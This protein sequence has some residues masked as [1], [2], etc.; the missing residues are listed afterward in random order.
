MNKYTLF[1]C[2][3]CNHSSTELAENQPNDGNILL[4]KIT[5]LSAE[6]FALEELKIQPVE[7]LWNCRGCVVAIAHPDKPTYMLINLPADE[8][9]ASA[10]LEFTKM[11]INDPLGGVNWDEL[12]QELD[13][14]FSGCIPSVINQEILES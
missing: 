13:S 10:L 4:D 7:C 9:N 14:A 5:A 8:E 1:V 3:S 6:K 2:E 12:P 11:Y